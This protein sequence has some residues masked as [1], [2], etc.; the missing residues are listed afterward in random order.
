MI[1]FK[2]NFFLR[3][4]SSSVFSPHAIFLEAWSD[5][6][7]QAILSYSSSKIP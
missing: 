3:S 7:I 6:S 5:E 2:E 4:L 1:F